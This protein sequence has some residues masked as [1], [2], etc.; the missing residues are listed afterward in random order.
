MIGGAG[1]Y[2]VSKGN[3]PDFERLLD[4]LRDV[5]AV[6]HPTF[7]SC[8]GFQLLVQALGGDVVLATDRREVGTF[9]VSLTPAGRSAELLGRLPPAFMAQ[10]GRKELARTLP[11]GVRHLA[12]SNLC[13][14]HALRLPDAPIWATQF[15]PELTHEDNRRRLLRY[16][17]AYGP[18]M[19]G[20]ALEEALAGFV[21]SP[22]T[23]RLIGDFLHLVFDYD[24]RIDS[25][26][27][28]TP[29]SS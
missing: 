1:D 15:H 5:V 10:V 24:P 11:D 29:T 12:A 25:R 6:A 7:A 8:F 21:P 4:L 9:E 17:A 22:E 2:D 20:D 13:S 27:S 19:D 28:S 23:E 14:Y 18:G 3:L 26:S 16:A